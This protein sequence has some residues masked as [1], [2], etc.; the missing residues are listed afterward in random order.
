MGVTAVS[1][2]AKDIPRLNMLADAYRF[3]DAG[4]VA[5]VIAKAVIADE[6]DPFAALFAA[7]VHLL[8][9]LVVGLDVFDHP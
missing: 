5:A 2:R 4:Q 3:G 8:V 1:H 6:T 9:P 7:I